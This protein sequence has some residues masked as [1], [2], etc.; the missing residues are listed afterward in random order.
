M[1][2]A[3]TLKAIIRPVAQSVPLFVHSVGLQSDWQTLCTAPNVVE[4]DSGVVVSSKVVKPGAI[5]RAAQAKWQPSGK[6]A[7][8]AVALR[9]NSDV[10]TPTSPVVRA[11]GKDGNGVWHVL[12]DAS[13]GTEITVTVATTTDVVQST[14]Y[15]ITKPVYFL[16]D[17][18]LEVIVAIQT[19]FAASSGTVND[20][21]LLGKGVI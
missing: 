12:Q 10:G 7:R 17:G 18:A 15:K 20:S 6:C 8:L 3:D 19:A 1:A 5:T 21:S 16:L 13:G 2:L 11:F 4:A 9:Y 14:A